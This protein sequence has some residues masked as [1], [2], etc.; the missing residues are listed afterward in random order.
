[1][2]DSGGHIQKQK[3]INGVLMCP[4]EVGAPVPGGSISVRPPPTNER[5][6]Q[7]GVRNLFVTPVE[8]ESHMPFHL[9]RSSMFLKSL[10]VKMEVGLTENY[11]QTN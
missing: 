2:G 7:A 3:Q 1:M 6:A 4:K 9:H 8:L 5:Q 10:K 11:P